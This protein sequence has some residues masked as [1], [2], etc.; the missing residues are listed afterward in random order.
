VHLLVVLEP[1][2]QKNGFKSAIL[3]ARMLMNVQFP[4]LWISRE[5]N[6]VRVLKAGQVASS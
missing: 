2:N 6:D 5:L 4:N 1:E 3:D